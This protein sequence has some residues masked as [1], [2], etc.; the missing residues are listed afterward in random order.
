MKDWTVEL[1]R[2]TG[3]GDPDRTALDTY[4]DALSDNHAAL[5]VTR[6]GRISSRLTVTTP[7]PPAAAA[8]ALEAEEAA[9]A[10]ARLGGHVT[11]VIVADA[12]T[13]DG[14][15]TWIRTPLLGLTDIA[16]RLGVS[17]Q[18][19]GQLANDHP[20]FPPAATRAGSGP[21]YE[22]VAI[23]AFQDNWERKAGRPVG[24]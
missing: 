20:L 12:D 5:S 4:L 18:R 24:V 14:E 6:Q 3:R 23:L 21:L 17:R 7:D 10:V 16:K 13:F 22:E 9:N 2:E 15:A 1:H 11:A 19:A 8:R